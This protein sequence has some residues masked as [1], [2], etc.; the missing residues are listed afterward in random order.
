[1]AG[2]RA[3]HEG[4]IRVT[5]RACKH[6]L[7]E[8]SSRCLQ[9]HAMLRYSRGL[10]L[11]LSH[12]ALGIRAASAE[13]QSALGSALSRRVPGSFA[14]G[15]GRRER[16]RAPRGIPSERRALG[17]PLQ[18]RLCPR[19]MPPSSSGCRRRSRCVPLHRSSGTGE[20]TY[21]SLCDRARA[22]PSHIGRGALSDKGK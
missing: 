20:R 14:P 21:A 12:R 7:Y 6:P 15:R 4:S 18:P 22:L 9:V 5:G 11:L 2:S 3:R 8:L 13:G 16:R 19:G 1:M 17:A 10:P